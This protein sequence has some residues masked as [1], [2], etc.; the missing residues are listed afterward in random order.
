MELASLAIAFLL[1]IAR[2]RQIEFK[3]RFVY[4][5]IP[6][7]A[8]TVL[9]SI[10]ILTEEARA[11]TY[12]IFIGAALAYFIGGAL[13]NAKIEYSRITKLWP[14]I[15][16]LILL[17]V[18]IYY[19]QT[20]KIDFPQEGMLKPVFPGGLVSTELS[21]IAAIILI[22]LY[23]TKTNS[24]AKSIHLGV[25]LSG[26]VLC[27][28]FFS[29]GTIA[30]LML[31]YMVYI[32]RESKLFV[33]SFKLMGT[34]IVVT[35]PFYIL[36][37]LGIVDSIWLL[38]YTDD[39]VFLRFEIYQGLYQTAINNPLTG[40]GVGKFYMPPHHNLLGLAA[41]TGFFSAGL[42]LVFAIGALI[43][44]YNIALKPSFNEYN[45]SY[46]YWMLW[47]IALFIFLK[48]FVHDTWQDKIFYFCLGY[49]ANNKWQKS[50]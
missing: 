16:G 23:F 7:I 34:I 40:I 42:Y 2:I 1:A 11:A 35:L 50:S 28:W 44:T 30:A 45:D 32:P 18:S 37:E 20:G 27:L 4:L 13:S 41:E 47:S 49:I 21:N 22:A 6:L 46:F 33:V 25:T 26:V 8:F 12:S 19:I 48:G 29:A 43:C 5:F 38:R 39:S 10:I 31:I 14:I 24:P 17:G 15:A 36:L 9:N 3:K